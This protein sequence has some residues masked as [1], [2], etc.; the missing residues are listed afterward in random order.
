MSLY[1]AKVSTEAGAAAIPSLLD[2]LEQH[3]ETVPRALAAI[4]APALPA[5]HQCLTNAPHYVPPCLLL[6]IPRERAVVSALGA[7][8]VAGNRGI[9]CDWV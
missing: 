2:L 6:E 8:F 9:G 1:Y 5:L 3:P 4:G 7:L